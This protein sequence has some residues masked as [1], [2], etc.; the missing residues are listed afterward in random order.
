MVS[1]TWT[2]GHDITL[3]YQFAPIHQ[4]TTHSPLDATPAKQCPSMG[5]LPGEANQ[6]ALLSICHPCFSLAEFAEVERTRF[7]LGGSIRGAVGNGALDD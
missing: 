4:A 7:D 5:A 6:A 1:G 2:M 3:K